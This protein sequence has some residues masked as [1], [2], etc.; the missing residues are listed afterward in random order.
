MAERRSPKDPITCDQVV[1]FR[2]DFLNRLQFSMVASNKP[3]SADRDGGPDAAP[4]W[5]GHLKPSVGATIHLIQ[6]LSG[7]TST[8]PNANSDAISQSPQGTSTK[9][10]RLSGNSFDNLVGVF[11]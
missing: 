4:I 5:F 8:Q 9:L 11:E 1:R 3:L 6:R 7:P 2:A 10:G